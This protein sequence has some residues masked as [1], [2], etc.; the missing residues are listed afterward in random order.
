[1]PFGTKA[2]A[3]GAIALKKG[4]LSLA[5]LRGEAEMAQKFADIE[6]LGAQELIRFLH[7]TAVQRGYSSYVDPATGCVRVQVCMPPI[8]LGES[9]RLML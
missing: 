9:N 5:A 4:P 6:D 2:G 1:M 3:M 7:K 8:S